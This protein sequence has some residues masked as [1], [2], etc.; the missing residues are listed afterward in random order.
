MHLQ[1]EWNLVTALESEWN[2]NGIRM[3][4]EW[5]L[6]GIRMESEWNETQSTVAG[7]GLHVGVM[8]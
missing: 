3:E 2:P 8:A 5:N 6:N 7:H 4:S 1:S